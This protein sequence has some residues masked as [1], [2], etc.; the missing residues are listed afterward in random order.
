MRHWPG[1]IFRGK[2]FTTTGPKNNTL[3]YTMVGV[4]ANARYSSLRTDPPPVF[5]VSY[6]QAPDLPWSMTFA[7]RT[8]MPRA[9]TTP[10]LQNAAQ[11]VDRDLPLI[12]VRTQKEQIDQITMSDRMF[13]DLTGGFGVLALVKPWDPATLAS[14]AGV[15]AAV[16]LTA[17][18]VPARRA[19]GIDPMQASRHE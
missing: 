3:L 14:A 9:A 19:A 13:A 12:E 8:R 17:S 2:T 18:W 5:Y 16:A 10:A 7:V 11:S 4:C 15:L 1:R 6:R